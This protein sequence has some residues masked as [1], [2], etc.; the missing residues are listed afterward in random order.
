MTGIFT[1]FN[2]VDV[3]FVVL[4]LLSAVFAFFRGFTREVL[5]IIAWFGAGIAVMYSFDEM[6]PFVRQY[7]SVPIVADIIAAGSVFVL[8][9]LLLSLITHSIASKIQRSVVGPL[10]RTLGM[11]FGVGRGFVM[12][13]VF[14]LVIISFYHDKAMPY[15][16]GESRSLPLMQ[17]GAK[18]LNSVIPDRLRGA[19]LP[20]IINP[21]SSPIPPKTTTDGGYKKSERGSLDQLFNRK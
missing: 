7:V 9:L 8:V 11:I 2:I 18:I 21:V 12:M 3:I 17:S 19:S 1:G 20:D 15:W 10:D 6:Q 13:A 4:T 14:Y 16:L 5:A